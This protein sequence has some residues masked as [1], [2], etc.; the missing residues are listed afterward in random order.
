VTGP[1]GGTAVRVSLRRIGDFTENLIRSIG[2]DAPKSDMAVQALARE[3]SNAFDSDPEGEPGRG[4]GRGRGAR[5]GSVALEIGSKRLSMRSGGIRQLTCRV[6]IAEKG[7]ADSKLT[8]TLVVGV[9]EGDESGP[10]PDTELVHLISV[11]DHRSVSIWRPSGNR[12]SNV[13]LQV[14]RLSFPL[15]VVVALDG[16]YAVA[17]DA[18]GRKI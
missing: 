2:P 3:L 13:D 18:R 1:D 17:I 8:I 6:S 16:P 4:S 9:V 12:V 15:R 11:E 14:N 7:F 5:S 10:V